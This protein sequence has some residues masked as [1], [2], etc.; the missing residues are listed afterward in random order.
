MWAK[1]K[2][3]EPCDWSPARVSAAAGLFKAKAVDEEQQGSSQQHKRQLDSRDETTMH[4]KQR[5]GAAND[6]RGASDV[7]AEGDGA[8]EK[9]ASKSTEPLQLETMVADWIRSTGF[10]AAVSP[11]CPLFARK[12]T[13]GHQLMDKRLLKHGAPI[14]ADAEISWDACAERALLRFTLSCDQGLGFGAHCV[15]TEGGAPMHGL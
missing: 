13:H 1:N 10:Q 9:E 12:F 2:K 5:V 4:K 3:S 7:E 14:P 15:G 6:S 8:Q 11:A